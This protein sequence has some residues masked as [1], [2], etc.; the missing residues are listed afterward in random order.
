MM[1]TKRRLSNQTF[2]VK[3]WNINGLEYKSHGM[4]CNKLNDPEV[5][6][7]LKTSDC[8]GLLETHADKLVDISL[9]GYH[10]FRKDRVKHKNANKPSGGIAVLVKESMRHLYKFDPISDSDVIWVRIQ[11]QFTSLSN[12]ICLAFVYLPP[13]NST[14]GKIHSKDIMLKL[15]KQIDYFAC[16]GKIVLCG[17]LNARIGNSV[18]IM[19]SDDEPYLPTPRADTFDVILPRVSSDYS[20]VNQSGRWLIDSCVD[21]QLYVLNGRTL[22]DLTGQF[23]CHTHR[24]SSI[25]DYI[26]ASRSLSNYVHSMIVHELGIFSDHCI[27]EAKLKLGSC[28]NF[29]DNDCLCDNKVKDFAPDNFIWYERSKDKF[30]EA[31]SSHLI[32][33][34][35]TKLQNIKENNESDTDQLID[36][37]TD[38]IVSAG[39]MTLTRKTFKRKKKK[40]HKL[41]KKWY[42]NDCHSTLRELKS[43]KNAFNRDTTN[44]NLRIRYYRQ[45]KKYTKLTKYKRRKFKEDLT[46]A[47]NEAIDNDPQK[48]WKLINEVKTESLPPDNAE[49]I[50]HQKWFDYFNELLNTELSHVD[51]SRQNAV[52]K[53]LSEFEFIHEKCNLD[54]A[55][56]EKEVLMAAKKLKNNKSSAYDMIKNEMIKSSLPFMSTL[57]TYTFNIILNTGKFPDLWKEG[58]VIPIHKN[59]SRVDPNNYRGITLSSCLGKLFCH[60]LNNRITSELETKSFLKHEQAGFRK[61]HRTA[62]HIFILR[63]I[64][65]KYVLN[66]KNGSKLYA[67][68]IDLKKAFDTVWHDGLFLKLHKAGIGGKVYNVI[69]SMYSNCHS[70][71]KYNK[72]MSD[73]ITITKG[74]H[75]GNVLSPMLFNVFINDIGDGFS[76]DHVPALHNSRISHLLYADDLLLLLQLLRVCSIT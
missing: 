43:I 68:F 1:Q 61:N 32:Q 62:D 13:L 2:S 31:F 14:Y 72:F 33:T 3:T 64:V 5:I 52:K 46:N 59:G 49:K 76:E 24:G 69:K 34:K 48:A 4:K 73:P 57:I 58:I 45:Y 23:T 27:L 67:C 66:S 36:A 19:Q 25:V 74:V 6:G 29:D 56:N 22:G 44:G 75:Q 70:R 63:T 47:L 37:I 17:D 26:L 7:M 42:D 50:N 11:K 39:D 9:P 8:I 10:V 51:K 71:I 65:D 21:N 16:K 20:V 15:E 55:I 35:L 53:E 40:T 60:V 30:Q 41:N 12:D 54:Y 38:V 18:D 28:L